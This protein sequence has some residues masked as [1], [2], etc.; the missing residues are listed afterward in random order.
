[1]TLFKQPP[2]SPS[3]V[4]ENAATIHG[5]KIATPWQKQGFGHTAFALAIDALKNEWPL[6]SKLM[7]AVDADNTAA[8]AVYRAFGMAQ[9]G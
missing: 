1:M 2:L 8:I 6:I 3:W 4:A 5:L 7:L 9:C